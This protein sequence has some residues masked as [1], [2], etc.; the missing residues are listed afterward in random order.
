MSIRPFSRPS[1]SCTLSAKPLKIEDFIREIND[2]G[3]TCLDT[4]E[5]IKG[6]FKQLKDDDDDI[7]EFFMGTDVNIRDY[8]NL[9]KPIVRYAIAVVIEKTGAQHPVT[10]GFLHRLS[11]MYSAD[12]MR[13]F[14]IVAYQKNDKTF[15][16][17]QVGAMLAC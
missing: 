11:R 4:L 8:Y 1:R 6:I 2:T 14:G 12:R 17:I 15:F 13:M 3:V 16:R 5:A 7:A 9:T 10:N